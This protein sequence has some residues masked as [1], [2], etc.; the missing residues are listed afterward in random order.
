MEDNH[1]CEAS[2]T[3]VA[4]Y[5]GR[6]V[7]GWRVEGDGMR[8]DAIVIEAGRPFGGEWPERQLWQIIEGEGRLS[9]DATAPTVHVRQGDGYRFGAGERRLIVAE[10]GMRIL[11]TPESASRSDSAP[12]QLL[13]PGVPR[14]PQQS[15]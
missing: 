12:Q 6:G 13:E 5:Q 7:Q 15:S 1:Y 10:T 3:E 11:I 4:A 9:G 2:L 8:Q 14:L